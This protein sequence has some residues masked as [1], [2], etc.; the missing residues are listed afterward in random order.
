[1]EWAIYKLKDGEERKIKIHWRKWPRLSILE[2]LVTSYHGKTGVRAERLCQAFIEHVIELTV[3]SG[4]KNSFI[5]DWGSMRDSLA[6]PRNVVETVWIIFSRNSVY[7]SQFQ[8]C[9]S[10]AFYLPA[11]S[12]FYMQCPH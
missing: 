5:Y 3:K 12:V 4:P 1:M 7:E 11:S 9:L 8:F 10:S 2:Y 6:Y